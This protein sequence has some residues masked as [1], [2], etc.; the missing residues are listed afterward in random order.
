MNRAIG[1]VA[2]L[3]GWKGKA[4]MAGISLA[5]MLAAITGPVRQ[6]S[7]AESISGILPER[8]RECVAPLLGSPE[9][10]RASP[11]A[12]LTPPALMC[13][14]A[15][16]NPDR[17]MVRYTGMDVAF[18]SANHQPDWVS[19]ELLGTETGGEA[20]RT[21]EFTRDGSVAGCPDTYEY[22]NSGYDRGHMAPAGD[23]K[24]DRKA[25]L[26]SFN[27]T[28][29]CP[30]HPE[31]NRGPWKK[32]EEKCREWAVRDSALVI[33]CGPVFAR[34]FRRPI[35]RTM[36][37]PVPR[38]FFKVVLAPYAK[39]PRAIAF[40]MGNTPDNGTLAQ[41]ST[42]VDSIEDLTGFDFFPALPDEI[43][44]SVEAQADFS[45]WR[46]PAATASRKT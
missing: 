40:L 42:T 20:G 13:V 4:G 16:A 7:T 22:S 21:D 6:C 9:A 1:L 32:L 11:G 10:K 31:L 23:M 12:A 38:A 30:Q 3:H 25:M 39:P 8:V 2:M 14:V 45:D 24:W 33:V 44:D 27:L 43:E 5:A 17:A 35:G 28:N 46:K 37:I 34:P 29:V 18:N 41:C 36:D 15:P 19:W 26:E